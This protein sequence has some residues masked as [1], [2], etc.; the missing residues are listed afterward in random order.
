MALAD[1]LQKSVRSTSLRDKARKG[2]DRSISPRVVRAAVVASV[3][4]VIAMVISF[5]GNV[6]ADYL[7]AVVAGFS[8]IFFT[9]VLSLAGYAATHSQGNGH[10]DDPRG[11]P[12]RRVAIGTGSI[13]GK[14]AMVQVLML[15]VALAIGATAIGFIFVVL[16]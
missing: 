7:L 5:S 13:S 4:F 15:P 8:V 10:R 16:Q 9:L 2:P 14:E 3:W 11:S 12:A 6:E 1:T